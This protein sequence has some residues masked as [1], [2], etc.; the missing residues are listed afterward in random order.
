MPNVSQNPAS[1]FM[2][3]G[4]VPNIAMEPFIYNH[5]SEYLVLS[6]EFTFKP[7]FSDFLKSKNDFS[8]CPLNAGIIIA[9]CIG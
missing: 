7:I 4:M 3:T 1:Y 5:L 2:I 8:L 9:G 6:I